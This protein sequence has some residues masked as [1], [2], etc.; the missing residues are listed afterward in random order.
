MMEAVREIP[1]TALLAGASAL[2]ACVFLVLVSAFRRSPKD[3]PP[4]VRTG[5]PV[6]GNIMAYVRSPMNVIRQGYEK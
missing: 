3:A 5:M 1:Q 2:A 6:L 4:F